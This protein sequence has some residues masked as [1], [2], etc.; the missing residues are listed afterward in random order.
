MRGGWRR[1][2]GWLSFAVM[3]HATFAPAAAA[4]A[5]AAPPTSAITFGVVLLG[6]S[7]AT[8]VGAAVALHSCIAEL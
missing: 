5:Q 6:G 4:V 8:A 1:T 7:L 2:A 3:T